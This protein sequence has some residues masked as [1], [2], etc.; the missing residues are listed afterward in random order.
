MADISELKRK[1]N[2][3]EYAQNVLRLPVRVP[4]DRCKSLAPGSN[5]PTAMVIFA[6]WWYDH[7]LGMGGDVIDLCAVA[8]HNGDRGKAIRELGGDNQ[9]WKEYTQN[10]CN[11]VALWHKQLRECD[12]LYLRRRRIYKET[13]DRLM[14]GFNDGRLVIPYWKNGY[15]CYYITRD[16][17]EESAVTDGCPPVI[18]DDFHL[19]GK[20]DTD[21][22]NNK[23]KVHK[24]K[25]A[26]KDGKN[27]NVPW[28]LHTLD[29][30][31]DFI[32]I[33]EGAFDAISFDQEGYIVI[34][35]M[36]G[37]FGKSAHKQAIDICKSMKKVYVCFD[38][39]EAGSSFQIRMAQELFQTNVP[40]FCATTDEKD[41][42]DYYAAGGDLQKLL[43]G[44]RDGLEVL[45][46]RITDKDEFKAFVFRAARRVGKPEMALLFEAV[47]AQ[48]H[49]DKTWLKMLE[50]Q[51]LAAPPEDL[52]AEE[53]LSTYRLKY[54]SALGFYE[55]AYGTWRRRSDEEIARYIDI[56]LGSYSTGSKLTAVLKIIKSRAVSTDLFDRQPVFNF[57][58]GTLD[59]ETGK[60]EGHNENFLCSMQVD[61]NY[62]ANAWSARWNQ[63]IGEIC[64]GDERK[65]CLLQE[66]AGYVLFTDNRLQKCFFLLG[67]GANGKSV[68]LDVLSA[69]FGQ[70]HISNVEISGLI[71]PFQ[72]IRL[73]NS[74]LNISSETQSNVKG[75]ESIFKQ[76]V[77]GDTV[78]GCYKN[79]DFIEFQ[80]RAKFVSACNEYIKSRDASTGFFRRICLVSFGAKF[81][82]DPEEGE[83]KADR[84]LTS[85]L[86]K[87]LPGIFNWC[88]QGYR[89]L[90]IQGSFTE[91]HE[92]AEMAKDFMQVTNPV[93]AFLE[94]A[95]L[96]PGRW[97]REG[98]YAKY[99]EWCK[100]AGHEALSRT[101]FVRRFRTTLKQLKR[102]DI[103]EYVYCGERG[104][105]IGA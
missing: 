95:D 26:T 86:K 96:Y 87:D 97:S 34:S 93:A 52:I 60:L 70:A 78:S 80:T 83:L 72:R 3:I 55:Y 85:K 18:C 43:D 98:I 51:A 38:S 36:G 44:A 33:A 66:I 4:G 68:F 57:L 79:K 11:G 62:D 56:A 102:K 77:V 90:T 65:M 5:N 69:V 1:I 105:E 6:D 99:K 7:K 22:Q 54:F 41:V 91:T 8:R 25:K 12:L 2:C 16:R 59:L 23:S 49:F 82:D 104:F 84:M 89:I 74:I 81:V 103:T 35:P 76:L 46:E 47:R 28:G 73:L 10:L 21:V 15:V 100:D 20:T 50:K 14:I 42:S 17:G 53:V 39:D 13:V 45:C 27:E 63:F 64:E 61:Y 58:N 48:G 29:R 40:F 75:A 24:Y 9:G 31:H 67:E 92:Q 94:E 19:T 37:H 30:E 88:Y 101:S 32:V 71:E